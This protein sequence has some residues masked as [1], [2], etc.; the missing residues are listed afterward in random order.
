MVADFG[1]ARLVAATDPGLSSSA[2]IAVGTPYY[3]SPEQWA[4]EPNLD[5][6]SDIY[7]LGCVVYE[8][9]SGEPPFTGATAETIRA[10]HRGQP[11]PPLRVA[12]PSLAPHVE[13]TLERALAKAPADRFRTVTEFAAALQ[14][15]EMAPVRR[16]RWGLP[17]AFSIAAALGLFALGLW[18][19]SRDREAG[20]GLNPAE[21]GVLPL[22]NETDLPV[23]R[24]LVAA[25]TDQLTSRLDTIPGLRVRP[26]TV[27]APLARE[28]HDVIVQRSG[29]GTIV[30]GRVTGTEAALRVTVAVVDGASGQQLGTDDWNAGSEQLLAA[31]DSLADEIVRF[32]RRAIGRYASL[33]TRL[34]SV[35]PEARRLIL[36][37]R[38]MLNEAAE[39]RSHRK[40]VDAH[41]RLRRADSLLQQAEQLDRESAV[42]AIERGWVANELINVAE[43]DSTL[44]GSWREQIVRGLAHADRALSKE[45]RS[46]AALE[47]RGFLRWRQA[48]RGDTT[49]FRPAEG[50]LREALRYND[51]LAVAWQLLSRIYLLHGNPEDAAAAARRALQYDPFLTE[52]R[53]TLLRLFQA[54]LELG[55]FD[56]ARRTCELGRRDHPGDL[57]FIE[58]RLVLLAWTGST[59][60]AADS[61][62]GE[63]HAIEAR[64]PS[65][66]EISGYRR[67]LVVAPLV[68]AGLLDSARSVLRQATSRVTHP[69]DWWEAR[70]LALLGETNGALERLRAHVAFW[71]E[72]RPRIRN[73]PW[74]GGLANDP[75]FRALVGS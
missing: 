11:V 27:M 14:K 26:Q 52:G 51:T 73:D 69:N 39:Y 44:A 48:E 43:Q 30:S 65:G 34:E 2:G 29:V 13:A 47:V 56:E 16:R 22:R 62:W 68:R 25:L 24:S 60:A 46:P 20:L 37:S 31:A 66:P 45:P 36:E 50:D 67:L 8:M 12:R 64:K 49:G 70:V 63:F 74:F 72:D 4:A 18:V 40:P 21:I 3:M 61:A 23:A 58:C 55:E 10:R 5:G 41:W 53:S 59:R 75:R 28:P 33:R 57:N 6:R 7:S 54:D 9:L 42:A 35:K 1:V 38:A 71:P 17:V 32:V 15:G 19:I